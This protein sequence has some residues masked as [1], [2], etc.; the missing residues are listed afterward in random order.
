MTNNDIL[1]KIQ[2]TLD[3]SDQ[4][5]VEIF[6]LGGLS[7][8]HELLHKWQKKSDGPDN[9]NCKDLEFA[10]FLNGLIIE[11]RGKKEGAEPKLEKILTNNIIFRKLIIAFNLK[12]DEVVNILE[13]AGFQISKYE[14]SALFRKPNHKNFRECKLKVL[15]SFLIGVQLKS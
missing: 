15:K 7:A 1:Q 4:K 13:L 8:S 10:N 5:M 6:I 2:D 9:Q 12:A 3:L 14:L 11:K